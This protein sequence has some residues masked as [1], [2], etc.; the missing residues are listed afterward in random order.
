M[1]KS[2]GGEQSRSQSDK[3]GQSGGS[4]H[5]GSSSVT[6]H[7]MESLLDPVLQ[8]RMHLNIELLQSLAW[9]LSASVVVIPIAVQSV[10]G[11]AN[12]LFVVWIIGM[13]FVGGIPM[14]KCIGR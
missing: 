1:H 2:L 14:G 9:G 3:K 13:W 8:I 6:S 7:T 11:P 5:K 10:D 4:I 12:V